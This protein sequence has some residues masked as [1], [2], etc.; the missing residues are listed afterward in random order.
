MAVDA[1]GQHTE[2]LAWHLD[3]GSSTDFRAAWLNGAHAFGHV[4]AATRERST[5]MQ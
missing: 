1:A 4:H 3:G 5:A 2:S